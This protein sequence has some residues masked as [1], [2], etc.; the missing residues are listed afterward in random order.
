M[1]LQEYRPDDHLVSGYSLTII[2]P[3]VADINNPKMSEL[4]AGFKIDG[5]LKSFEF[6]TD[7]D[8]KERKMLSD[9]NSTESVGKRTY[10]TADTEIMSDDPQK[11]SEL[12]KVLVP[13]AI[14]YFIVRPGVDRDKALEA[15][16]RLWVNR[17]QV[18]S[19]DPTEVNTDD[20]TYYAWK[21]SWATKA[22]T[23]NA[24]IAA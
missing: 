23:Y 18:I 16:Q 2:C 5:A 24:K 14:V 4:E 13:D 20:G 8:T 12:E 3:Q 6:S 9:K 11:V 19:I 15:G 21:V 10:K 7:A 17:Q 22:R 1:A